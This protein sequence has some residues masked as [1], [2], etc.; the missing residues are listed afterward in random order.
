MSETIQLVH[1]EETTLRSHTAGETPA[2][3]QA[4]VD[5][6]AAL[7]TG[8][9]G[10]GANYLAYVRTTGQTQVSRTATFVVAASDASAAAKAQADYVCDG[11]ADEV[12]IQEAIDALPSA[13]GGGI[14]LSNGHFYLS[15]TVILRVSGSGYFGI[16]FQGQGPGA[17]HIVNQ[18]EAGAHALSLSD[19]YFFTVK[20]MTIRGNALSGDAISCNFATN[21]MMHLLENLDLRDNGG[22]GVNVA[23]HTPD[24]INLVRLYCQANALG[25]IKT[26]GNYW[27]IFQCRT[28][29]HTGKIG[30]DASVGGEHRISDCTSES[31][32]I[33]VKIVSGSVLTGYYG[34]NTTN[35]ILITGGGWVRVVGGYHEATLPDITLIKVSV[36]FCHIGRNT[37]ASLAAG[38]TAIELTEDKIRVEP[39]GWSQTNDAT[40]IK[41]KNSA[42]A[43]NSIGD[44]QYNLNLDSSSRAIVTGI[45]SDQNI[46]SNGCGEA[47]T[48]SWDALNGAIITSEST[49]VKRGS[50][51][52]K[53]TGHA[54]TAYS[55]GKVAIPNYLD[56]AGIPVTLSGW[57]YAPSTNTIANGQRVLLNADTASQ[58]APIV[59]PRTD[60]WTWI[61]FTLLMP[62]DPSY[63]WMCLMANQADGGADVIYG[64]GITLV[65]GTKAPYPSPKP[66][67]N[68]IVH[69]TAAFTI[70]AYESGHVIHTNLGAGGA[71]AFTLPQ[72]VAAGFTCRF[73][74]MA[75]QELRIDPGVAGA[76]YINGAKQTDD[77][78]ISAD[79]E[80]ESIILTAD[81]NGDWI[82]SSMV[83]TWTVET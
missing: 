18:N 22:W 30:I 59:V 15:D 74:V 27:K 1:G 19:M 21:S 57:F 52:I 48:A 32:D 31:N 38:C 51:S 71:I 83:G 2:D 63:L 12:Q 20:D 42:K 64:D 60:T 80:A 24:G 33:G 39:Q 68:L 75:A 73:A 11:T 53:V 6:H 14:T 82:T 25:G 56:Y 43:D 81:G 47:G 40:S 45:D 79:D 34:L 35:D 46:L 13:I 69:H 67:D 26:A 50:K 62:T 8:V 5:T 4:K 10:A 58:Y 36:P 9:H 28:N 55:M 23:A 70:S 49:I 17:T 41:V 3:T 54:V 37:F 7:T 76:I 72:T 77:K 61:T 65:P 78:Y 66:N 29:S 44:Q 16:T